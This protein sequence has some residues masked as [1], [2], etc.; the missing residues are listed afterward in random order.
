VQIGSTG[1]LLAIHAIQLIFRI[2]ATYGLE[3]QTIIAR[4]DGTNTA[5]WA[6]PGHMRSASSATA[7]VETG[8]SLIVSRKYEILANAA[9]EITA[10]AS[11][12]IT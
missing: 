6:G 8:R 1:A 5:R 3:E 10:N 2:E 11:L 9:L 12:E 7:T 4:G